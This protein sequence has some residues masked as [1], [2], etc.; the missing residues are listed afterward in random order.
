MKLTL[1]SIFA[2][3]R[4]AVRFLMLS[5]DAKGKFHIPGKTMTEMQNELGLTRGDTFSIG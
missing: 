4:R 5:P 1:C 3:G 2:K